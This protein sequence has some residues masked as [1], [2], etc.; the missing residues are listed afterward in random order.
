MRL[1]AIP[2]PAID[3]VAF[4]LGPLSVKWYGLAYM[5]G[6]LLGW[7]YIKYL[8]TQDRLWPASKRPFSPERADDLLLVMT[9][10]VLLGGRLGYVLFYEPRFFLSNPLEIPAVWNGGM[11][12]HGALIGSII[13]MVLFARRAGAEPWSVMDVCAAATPMGLFFGRLANFINAELWGRPSTVPWSMVFPGAGPVS[14]HPSQLYEAFF[15]GL[16]LFAVLYWLTHYRHGLR[17]PGVIAGTFLA[18]Y[19]LARSFCELFREP[20]PG[21][22]LTIGPF[23]AG[24]L[25]SLPMILAGILVVRAAGRRT[26]AAADVRQ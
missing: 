23:T 12:F 7:L 26:P 10:G 20:D 16:V 13:A 17:R 1:L 8:L 9:V 18:G 24:I 5:A 15:E 6:L 3:P 2:F 19:G 21:H 14:R 11:S 25:Y 4:H 22:V